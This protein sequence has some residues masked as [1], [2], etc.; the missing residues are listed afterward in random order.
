M[1][2]CAKMIRAGARSVVY[3]MDYTSFANTRADSSKMSYDDYIALF[4][5]LNMSVTDILATY[6]CPDEHFSDALHDY[7]LDNEPAVDAIFACLRPGVDPLVS[8]TMTHFIDIR[9]RS[10][11]DRVLA[12]A[13]QIDWDV[14]SWSICDYL[15]DDDASMMQVAE[16]INRF[17]AYIS[18]D[19]LVRQLGLWSAF[20]PL[21][22]A[23]DQL[24]DWRQFHTGD[25][26]MAVKYADRLDWALISS[27][28]CMFNSITDAQFAAIA[29]R[30]SWQDLHT[31][32]NLET[33]FV[34]THFD[35][36]SDYETMAEHG[37]PFP[38]TAFLA[39]NS[40]RIP[41][42]IVRYL[43]N[44]EKLALVNAL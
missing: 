13:A 9:D 3:R 6:G 19:T 43:G 33:S 18:W 44:R 1:S 27:N 31:N 29:H 41:L 20:E 7:C 23:A 35:Q 16:F 30:V 11:Y 17:F 2:G 15:C 5:Q 34:E 39:A 8:G 22:V 25:Y 26:A 38:R 28:S 40:S 10:V 32:S 14:I 12:H 4:R 36:F 37:V 42:S 24:I 21:Y